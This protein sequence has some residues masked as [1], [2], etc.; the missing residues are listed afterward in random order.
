MKMRSIL[1]LAITAILSI[2][3]MACMT[4]TEPS[5]QRTPETLELATVEQDSVTPIDD[6]PITQARSC[7][8]LCPATVTATGASCGSFL[9]LGRTTFLGSCSK[10]CGFARDDAAAQAAAVSCHLSGLCTGGC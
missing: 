6:G 10:A 5:S 4:D 1:L 3:W 9:G 8:Q 7:E 2:A